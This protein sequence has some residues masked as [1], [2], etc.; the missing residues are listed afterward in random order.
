L[1]ID[2]TSGL[3]WIVSMPGRK[4]LTLPQL[5]AKLTSTQASRDAVPVRCRNGYA[6]DA[7]HRH[8]MTAIPP[9]M[10]ETTGAVPLSVV[11]GGGMNI[12]L[13]PEGCL[14]ASELNAI[15]FLSVSPGFRD[16]VN[17]AGIHCRSL[18]TIL[19][20]HSAPTSR[21]Y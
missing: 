3:D 7:L 2:G 20:N 13:A 1:Y 9:V 8:G 15:G 6:Q 4:R 17:H 11:E 19:A 18:L 10:E 16:L 12:I 14:E 21:W 5:V